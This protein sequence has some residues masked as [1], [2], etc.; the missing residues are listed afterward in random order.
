MSGKDNNWKSTAINLR[1]PIFDQMVQLN[2][3]I[4]MR[5]RVRLDQ[6][7]EYM[8]LPE[9]QRPPDT[10]DWPITLAGIVREALDE[11]LASHPKNLRKG[12]KG[13]RP[14]AAETKPKKPKASKIRKK[15]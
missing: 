9:D 4:P 1:E 11:W 14:P 6:Y 8:N 12:G 10:I 13:A 3:R 15:E 7:Q 2:V 5:V